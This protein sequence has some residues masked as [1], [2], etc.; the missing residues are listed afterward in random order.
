MISLDMTFA[1]EREVKSQL[2]P[3]DFIFTLYSK[4]SKKQVKQLS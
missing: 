3:L 4:K 2:S 1:V